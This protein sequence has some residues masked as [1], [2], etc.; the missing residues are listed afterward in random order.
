ML[1]AGGLVS[2]SGSTR[3]VRQGLVHGLGCAQARCR[4]GGLAAPALGKRGPPD[5]SCPALPF[6]SDTVSLPRWASSSSL[7]NVLS[8]TSPFGQILFPSCGRGC[9]QS[10]GCTWGEAGGG[11][12]TMSAVPG[13]A[14][15][16]PQEA[17]LRRLSAPA[18]VVFPRR[19]LSL[20]HEAFG[21]ESLL[22]LVTS[23]DEKREIAVCVFAAFSLLH[24]IPDGVYF[25]GTK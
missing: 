10:L 18:P 5:V 8:L 9:L 19:L 25:M 3:Q 2:E 13:A 15:P 6:S 4:P 12:S 11:Q 17:C 24:G 21:R 14:G 23:S 1:S 20:F 22:P 16:G 7:F